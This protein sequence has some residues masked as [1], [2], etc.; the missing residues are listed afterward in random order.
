MTKEGVALTNIFSSSMRLSG[1]SLYSESYMQRMDE[2]AS[3][4]TIPARP[5]LYC[6][7]SSF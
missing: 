1:S 7:S 2:R 4:S 5:Y 6:S 3:R